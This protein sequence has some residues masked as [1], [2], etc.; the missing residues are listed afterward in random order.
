MDGSSSTW[1]IEEG[2]ISHNGPSK[3]I[4]EIDGLK[5]KEMILRR[6]KEGVRVQNEGENNP[7]SISLVTEGM[8]EMHLTQ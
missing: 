6:P 8:V 5:N 7:M 3:T 2:A 4:Y 1:V